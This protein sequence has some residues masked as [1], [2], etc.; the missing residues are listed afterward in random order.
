[1][2]KTS[3][4]TEFLYTKECKR[5]VV[6]PMQGPKENGTYIYEKQLQEKRKVLKSLKMKD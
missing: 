3:E 5:I 1:M 2:G 6:K 4:S